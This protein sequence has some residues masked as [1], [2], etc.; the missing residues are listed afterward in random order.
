MTDVPMDT[1]LLLH[2]SEEEGFDG[3]YRV[4]CLTSDPPVGWYDAEGDEIEEE[5]THWAPVPV[6]R[7]MEKVRL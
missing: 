2:W 1:T 4:G 3:G 5:P 7:I 6:A